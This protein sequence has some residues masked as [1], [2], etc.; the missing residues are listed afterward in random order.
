MEPILEIKG[1]SKR[2]G[3]LAAVDNFNLRV[4]KGEMIGLIGP[5]GAGKTTLYNLVTGLLKPDSGNVF[6]E[7]KDITRFK[8]HKIA[9][10]G[11]ART[12][13]NTQAFRRMLVIENVGVANFSPRAKSRAN[14]D[15]DYL[16]KSLEALRRVKL[17]PPEENIFKLANQLSHG[18]SKRLDIARVLVLEPDLLLLDEPFGGLGTIEMGIMSSL[19]E[20]LHE[21][22]LTIVIIEHKMRAL[23]KLVKK[24]VVMHFGEN[25]AEGAPSDIA[26]DP[27]VCEAYVGKG[28]GGLIA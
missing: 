25:I 23:A 27:K 10:L 5:N 4:R 1:L 21:G 26:R 28:G 16:S 9:N 11:I 18:M 19:I 2:F 22:G 14:G 3:G 6:F 24:L 13:Q 20:E 15:G 12:F 17:V 8:P 7:G